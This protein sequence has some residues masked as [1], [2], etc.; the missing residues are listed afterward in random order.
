LGFF[1]PATKGRK[2]RA[3]HDIG[4]TAEMLVVEKRGKEEKK[5]NK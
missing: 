2:L 1:R 5:I 3:Q 4:L